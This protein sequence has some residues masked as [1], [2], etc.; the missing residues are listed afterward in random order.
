MHKDGV[1]TARG[2]LVVVKQYL[3]GKLVFED[4]R[5]SSATVSGDRFDHTCVRSDNDVT[6]LALYVHTAMK[7]VAFG[8]CHEARTKCTRNVI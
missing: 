8:R 1:K 2:W 6:L 4:Y 5:E 3:V 7:V